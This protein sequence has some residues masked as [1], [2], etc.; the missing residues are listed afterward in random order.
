MLKLIS[1]IA[2][3][4]FSS[5]ISGQLCNGSLGDPVVNMTFGNGGGS[6]GFVPSASYTYTSSTCP[7]DGFYTITKTTSNCFGD[8]WH[9]L[10]NDHTGGGAFM[11]VNASYTPGDFFVTTVTDLCPNTTYEFAAW[12]LNIMK[13]YGSILPNLTFRVETPTGIVLNTF[14]TGDIPVTNAPQWNQYGFYFSTPSDNAVIVLRITN[15]APGGI[16]NDLALDDITFRPC[17]SKI[18]AAISGMAS[19]TINLCDGQTDGNAYTFSSSVSSGYS[20]PLFQ[21]QISRDRGN[22]WNDIPGA[23]SL[24]YQT[25][26]ISGAG[27]N[28]Y[29]MSVV[30]ASV[31]NIS[32]CRIVSDVLAINVH[33]KPVVNA[34]PDKIM[35]ADNPIVLSGDVQGDE[36]SYVWS[37]DIYMNDPNQLTPTVSPPKNIS[38]TLTAQS[39]WGCNNSDNVNVKVVSHIYI[40]NA[41]TPN[42]DGLNDKWEIPFLDPSFGGEVSVYNRWGQ[43]VYYAHS[44]AV[45]WDGTFNGDPQPA[46]IYIYTITI[47]KYNIKLKGTIR[48]IR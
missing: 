11:L 32:S 31:A 37:P 1:T 40:P 17:G 23:T 21:W 46:S 30:D 28:W 47:K 44:R 35:L 19:D 8:T 5:A 42:G 3:Q 29:R 18:F 10:S 26:T 41:F 27:M 24:D 39:V 25:P 4:I 13:V 20:S 22:T 9:N 2:L 38:Y 14:N 36:P 48:L 15:N 12:I 16:G 33:S 43:R 34:G 7:N 6:S 45:S